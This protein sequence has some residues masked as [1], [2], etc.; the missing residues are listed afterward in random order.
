MLVGIVDDLSGAIQTTRWCLSE[1]NF[2]NWHLWGYAGQIGRHRNGFEMVNPK[3]G[4][5]LAYTKIGFLLYSW[6]LLLALEVLEEMG[7]PTY[8]FF[9]AYFLIEWTPDLL[10]VIRQFE[11]YMLETMTTRLKI[12]LSRFIDHKDQD[13]KLPKYIFLMLNE[14]VAGHALLPE[15]YH[16]VVWSR[17]KER[18]TEF[19]PHVICVD[20]LHHGEGCWCGLIFQSVP[21]H[22]IRFYGVLVVADDNG[23]QWR[24]F[25]AKHCSCIHRSGGLKI[26]KMHK[27][28]RYRRNVRSA[29][30]NHLRLV[31]EAFFIYANKWQ[32]FE[33]ITFTN[34]LLMVDW[35][36]WRRRMFLA[37][38]YITAEQFL[39][40]SLNHT[41]EKIQHADRSGN[42]VPR[43]AIDTFHLILMA[44]KIW[45]LRA[46]LPGHPTIDGLERAYRKSLVSEGKESLLDHLLQMK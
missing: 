17:R 8:M 14:S 31:L 20:P 46:N 27:N 15:E 5:V 36:T 29:F 35:E 25:I 19:L 9:L 4:Q 3:L 10:P 24:N 2:D 28:G 22:I 32:G 13:L 16:G 6:K 38:L 33:V 1:G 7:N 45:T 21:L 40:T 44:R 43:A 26:Y 23:S 11:E 37:V 39:I 41:P 42:R 18:T 30:Q 34:R 12:G